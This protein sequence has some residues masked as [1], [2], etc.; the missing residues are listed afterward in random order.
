MLVPLEFAAKGNAILTRRP[1][2]AIPVPKSSAATSDKPPD[3]MFR[4]VTAGRSEA[5]PGWIGALLGPSKSGAISRQMFD[6][7]HAHCKLDDAIVEAL[8]LPDVR[9][10][11]ERLS[12]LHPVL[13]IRLLHSTSARAAQLIS[14]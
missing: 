6:K 9:S 14:G 1:A 2:E 3:I 13:T 7:I 8:A 5:P 4:L 12:S 11:W 10:A